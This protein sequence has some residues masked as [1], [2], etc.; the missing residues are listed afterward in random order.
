MN[1]VLGYRCSIMKGELNYSFIQFFTFIY[2]HKGNPL[3]FV[4]MY[5]EIA[6][7]IL[8]F[9]QTPEIYIFWWKIKLYAL[10]TQSF[11]TRNVFGKCSTLK[12][13]TILYI[14]LFCQ[15]REMAANLMQN[16]RWRSLWRPTS[17]AFLRNVYICI[18]IQNFF[19]IL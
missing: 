7:S 18:Y 9:L 11:W 8:F 16:M 14:F 1:N 10:F 4:F 13:N 5:I 6:L 15:F 17:N 12:R 19:Y 2:L 3:K